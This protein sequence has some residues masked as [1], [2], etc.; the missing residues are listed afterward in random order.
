MA[1]IYFIL[2]LSSIDYVDHRL[3]C[4]IN[5]ILNIIYFTIIAYNNKIVFTDPVNLI[6]FENNHIGLV[7][8]CV[9]ASS[10][11]A[12]REVDPRSGQSKD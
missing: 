1:V 12:D 11:D 5:I 8:V 7:I 10:V 9:L 3:G 6:F 4:Q 2:E